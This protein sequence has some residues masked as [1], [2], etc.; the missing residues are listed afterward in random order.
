[1]KTIIALGGSTSKKSINAQ[2][3]SYAA[4]QV[5]NVQVQPLNLNDFELPLY[6]VDLEGEAGIPEN[7][8]K[9][10]DTLAGAD[11]IVLSLAEHNGSYSAAFKNAMD[12]VSRIDMKI[13]KEKPML[14]MATS[15]GG[16]GGATVLATAAQ[17]FPHLGAQVVAQFA[18][19][20]FGQN[21]TENGLAD[22]ELQKTFDQALEKFSQ[23]L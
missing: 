17:S 7:A 8:Q 15:P 13:W 22:G 18:L 23:A 11:G 6:S 10:N 5:P 12:W 16:R 3:A 2:W 19:P 20:S 21:F 4:H 9:L 1:M 14:L